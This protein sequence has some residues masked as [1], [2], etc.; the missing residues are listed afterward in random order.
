MS[1]RNLTFVVSILLSAQAVSSATLVVLNKA[2]ATASLIDIESGVVLATLP[3]DVGP[4]EV[5]ISPDGTIALACNYGTRAAPGS[6]ITVIDI[7]DR[8][9]LKTIDLGDYRRPHGVTWL[10][11]GRRAVVTT[12]AQ[13]ALLVVDIESGKISE[14][15]ETDQEISH[16]VAVTP[17][18]RRAFVANI[19]SGSVTAIDLE[20]GERIAQILTGEGAEGIDITPDG[21]EVWV[22]N[23][24]VNTL[25]VIDVSTLKITETLEVG[26]FPIR[27]TITPE[28]NHVL[29]SNARSADVAV[30][31]AKTKRMIRRVSMQRGEATTD[32]KLFGDQF[33]DSSIPIGIVVE[34]R[35]SRAWIALAG[36]DLIAELDLVT[37]RLTRT[38]KAGREPDG[39]AYSPVELR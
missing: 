2:E 28:G 21:R 13:K 20:E 26:E 38:L 22:T 8:K 31:D 1:F 23:R 33:G 7:E 6:T 11:D 14:A 19:G 36:S 34:P 12:E 17:D 39:M 5:A 18:G 25:S 3:T 30:F 9:V 4:H 32:G 37:W 24:A 27:V 29:V 35:G 10:S 16:M 15:I